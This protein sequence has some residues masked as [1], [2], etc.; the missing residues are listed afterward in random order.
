MKTIVTLLTLLPLIMLAQQTPTNPAGRYTDGFDGLDGTEVTE[1]VLYT[2][3]TFKLVTVDPVF[4]YTY[5]KYATTGNWTVVGSSVILN[6]DLE[7]RE[8][9]INVAE[10]YVGSEDSLTVKINYFLEVYRN[11]ELVSIKPFD[12]DM[13]TISLNKPKK[14][15]NIVK[16]RKYSIC[17]FAPSIKRQVL[18]D[19]TTNI[20]KLPHKDLKTIW[21][22]SYG[23]DRPHKFIISDPATNFL[24]ITIT[25]PID[26]ERMPRSKEIIINKEKVYFYEHNGK[27]VTSGL[28][29]PLYKQNK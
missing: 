22:Y 16:H 14:R 21:V 25:Q 20:V 19:S 23:F 13:L 8:L 12:F 24:E 27:V 6:N 17:M 7:P 26:E 4:S 11:E 2:D 29:S 1:L 15:Y 9:V 3:S 28:L 5:K 10:S 18:I